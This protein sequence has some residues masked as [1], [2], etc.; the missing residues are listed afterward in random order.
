MLSSFEKKALASH[1]LSQ[2]YPMYSIPL[3]NKCKT[4]T[5]APTA[6]QVQSSKLRFDERSVRHFLIESSP[7]A[8]TKIVE[9]KSQTMSPRQPKSLMEPNSRSA[10]PE[11]SIV[12]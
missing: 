9:K 7:I 1:V 11:N 4:Y 10:R 12:P 2:T 6:Q 5:T 3:F 8:A